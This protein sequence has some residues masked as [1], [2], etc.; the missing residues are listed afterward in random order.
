MQSANLLQQVLIVVVRTYTLPQTHGLTSEQA[1]HL[2]HR[3]LPFSLIRWLLAWIV[4]RVFL[5]KFSE[6]SASAPVA[7]YDDSA[8]LRES[9][10]YKVK[11]ENLLFHDTLPKASVPY[12]SNLC[13]TLSLPP[14]WSSLLP[15]VPQVAIA[16]WRLLVCQA[17]PFKNQTKHLE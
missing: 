2:G 17:L 1:C 16:H 8:R 4:G 12:N 11:K 13:S 15:R 3:C 9:S 10:L 14:Q 6:Q 7:S 5:W